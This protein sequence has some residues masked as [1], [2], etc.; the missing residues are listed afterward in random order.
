M[1]SH[2]RSRFCISWDYGRADLSRDLEPGEVESISMTLRAPH[3]PGRYIVE[4]DMVSEHIA[5]FEDFSSGTLRHEL[6]VK[7]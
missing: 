4:F 2:T 6:V 3:E 1:F 5:G 7:E